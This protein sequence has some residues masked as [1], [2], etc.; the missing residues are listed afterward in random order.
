MD[1][2]RY[3]VNI[4]PFLLSNEVGARRTVPTHVCFPRMLFR[5]RNWVPGSGCE[6]LDSEVVQ[7]NYSGGGG[8]GGSHWVDLYA[9]KSVYTACQNYRYTCCVLNLLI[10]NS[11]SVLQKL[12]YKL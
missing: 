2:P 7:N 9:L 3:P 1:I 4:P 8:G 5:S 12:Y 10:L 11:S 6:A